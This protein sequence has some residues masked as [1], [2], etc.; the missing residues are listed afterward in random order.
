MVFRDKDTKVL[1]SFCVSGEKHVVAQYM[2]RYDFT[3]SKTHS[4]KL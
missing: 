2:R 3:F 1:Q 4:R